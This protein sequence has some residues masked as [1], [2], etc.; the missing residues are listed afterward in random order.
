L[1]RK[2][3]QTATLKRPAPEPVERPADAIQAAPA[4][5]AP[6]A[7]VRVIIALIGL[8]V[9]HYALAA[10]SLLRENPTVDEVAHLPAGITYWQKGT[11]RLYHHNPPLFKLVAALPVVMARP[12][13]EPLY[14]M[15]SWTSRS[16]SQA[17]FSQSFARFNA[18]RY[19]EL[20]QLARLMMPLFT[21]VGG[22]IV[23]VWSARLYGRLAGL[24][25]LALWAFCP[26][27]LAHARLV[28]SDACS[29]AMGVAAT[30]AFWRYL[31][32]PNGKRATAAGV[33]LGIAQ[34]SKFSM[35]LLYAVWPFLWLSH[36]VM[37]GARAEAGDRCAVS[38]FR[39]IGRGLGHGIAI[40]ALSI[41]TIDVGYFF[42]GVGVPL[43]DH[44]FGS[45]TLTRPV[46]PGTVR[47]HSENEILE[48]TWQFRVNRFR[49]T[50]LGGLPMPLPRHYLLGFDEQK[51]ETEGLPR[52]YFDAIRTRNAAAIDEVRRTPEADQGEKAA[53]TVYLDGE[54]R[55]TGWR[56]YYL[57]ALRYK[58]PEGTWLL[59]AL[60]LVALVAAKRPLAGW[61]DE[62]TLWVLPAV[63]LLSMS[64]L[65]DINLGLRYVLAILPYVF[66]ST[67]KVVPWCLGLRDPWRRIAGTF[68]AGCLGLTITA[69]AWIYPSYL[70]YFN[71]AS[72]GPDRV[73][74]HLID[75]NLDWGQD[76]V[77]LQRWWRANIPGQPLGLAYFGQINPS[78]FE[79]RGE[80]FR[81]FLPPARPG[82]VQTMRAAPSPRLIGPAR[83]LTPGY[84][85]VSA[86]LLYGLPWRL[87]D[88]A[89][90]SSAPEANQ[91]VWNFHDPEALS[92]FRQFRPIMPPIGHS[93]YVFRLTEADVARVNPLLE[94]RPR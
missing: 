17:T 43:G 18:N 33:L 65:T 57:L 2:S 12:V 69:S 70:S 73:P 1:A 38:A 72:G 78:I 14:L 92:Y 67:G 21:V 93:I 88:P 10:R 3:K 91:P 51:I 53:Y 9:L 60:S 16:P 86:T 77:E 19:F 4:P 66:I 85:A 27:I 58:V 24:L 87:Y 81:W 76:L 48:A 23:F 56:S 74:P 68:I 83:K 61:F 8:L 75:S 32:Q 64:L 41:L 37:V 80:P 5:D 29:T 71:W 94:E 31:H 79:L 47:P 44:E 54:L 20:F 22:L 25:S 90:P 35:L 39:P 49:D 46:P 7:R 15:P 26:N 36:R 45:R 84:Y 11:F 55:M 89:S 6:R 63:I 50:W 30:Y 40:V 62:L 59:V 28:T 13:T 42:E 82:T 34:L 52:R